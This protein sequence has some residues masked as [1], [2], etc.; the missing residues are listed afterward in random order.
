M[1]LIIRHLMQRRAK[2]ANEFD[3]VATA[4]NLACLKEPKFEYALEKAIL[5]GGFDYRIY[6][7]QHQAIW[8]AE[9]AMRLNKKGCFVEIGTAKGYI[10]MSILSALEYQEKDLSTVPIYLF[11]TFSPHATDSR[12]LQHPKFGKISIAQSQLNT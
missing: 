3:G 1:A 7:R 4:H 5:A 10:M 12:G 2:F 11:D 6:M 9:T 8:C